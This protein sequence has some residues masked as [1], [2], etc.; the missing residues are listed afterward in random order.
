MGLLIALIS[1]SV[2]ATPMRDALELEMIRAALGNLSEVSV[3]VEDTDADGGGCDVSRSDLDAAVRETL[4]N[5]RIRVRPPGDVVES[6]RV[7]V[8]T[9]SGGS[10]CSGSYFVSLRRNVTVRETG[11][12]AMGDVWHRSGVTTGPSHEFGQRVTAALQ[13]VVDDFLSDWIK[14]NPNPAGTR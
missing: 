12:Y 10:G 11:R 1:P 13:S 2:G 5:S 7:S 3:V 6:V 9:F 14:A 8:Q 4:E